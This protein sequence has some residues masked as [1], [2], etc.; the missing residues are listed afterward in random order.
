MIHRIMEGVG[1]VV[2]LAG[3]ELAVIYATGCCFR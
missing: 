2:V 3:A 1:W